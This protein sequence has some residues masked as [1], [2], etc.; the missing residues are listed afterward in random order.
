MWL[1]ILYGERQSIVP[2]T[3]GY[4]ASHGRAGTEHSLFIWLVATTLLPRLLRGSQMGDPEVLELLFELGHR[5]A[6][7]GPYSEDGWLKLHQFLWQQGK[8]LSHQNHGL[9]VGEGQEM[10]QEATPWAP[11]H[12]QHSGLL[13]IVFQDTGSAL[14]G[15]PASSVLVFAERT[16]ETQLGQ[17]LSSCQLARSRAG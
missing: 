14:Q 12:P 9:G 3:Q 11:A 1:S 15:G 16:T 8:F 7:Q 10:R 17:N 4:T 5:Q 2:A 13:D 6:M